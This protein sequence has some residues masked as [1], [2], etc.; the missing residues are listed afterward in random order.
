ME[1]N[2]TYK[3]YDIKIVH[4]DNPE[5]PMTSWDGHAPMIVVSGRDVWDYPSDALKDIIR[6]IEAK[7]KA[8]HWEAMKKALDIEDDPTEWD[9]H[10][11][12]NQEDYQA[13]LVGEALGG[14]SVNLSG[15]Y[16]ALVDA[17]D[18]V[19]IPHVNGCT[20]GYSQGDYADCL[21]VMTDAFFEET[22]CDRKNSEEI[23]EQ[24]IKLYGYWAWGDVYGYVVEDPM[25]TDSDSCCGFYGDHDES[26]LMDTAKEWIDWHI[27]Q[28]RYR[29]YDLVKTWIKNS[30]PFTHRYQL[31]LP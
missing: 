29:H 25:S 26:G 5:N 28:Q 31:Q 30:V 14:L 27:K 12:G 11:Y 7:Y 18:T 24:Q 3:G 2:T 15:D 10:G 13:D 20:R 9:G 23:G 6:E 17:L 19:G 21:V 1:E 22:G 16:D 4:H 8:E